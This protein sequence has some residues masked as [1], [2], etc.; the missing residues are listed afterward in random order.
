[1]QIPSIGKIRYK[2]NYK[3]PYGRNVKFSNPRITY[4]SSSH[5]WI[6]SVGIECENQAH[7]LTDRIAGIDLGIKELAVVAIGNEKMV[8]HNINKAK[9]MRNLYSKQKYIQRI[10]SRKY[11]TNNRIHPSEKWKKTNQILKYERIL[12]SIYCKMR[13][14]RNDYLHKTTHAIISNLPCEIVMETLDV[15]D[16]MKNRYLAQKISDQCFHEFIRQMRYKCEYNGIKFTQ[17]DRFYPSS[18]TCSC[19]GAI[20]TDLKLSDRIYCCST[21]GLKIDRDLNA[22]INLKKYAELSRE[23][24]A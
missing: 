2:T 18:K 16:M 4:I 21:C 15:Q 7:E 3:I 5:K 11:E 13:N 9:R 10:I 22:A 6:L 14:I 20:K 1:M 8:F 24:V 19:C 23:P 17:V 12:Q